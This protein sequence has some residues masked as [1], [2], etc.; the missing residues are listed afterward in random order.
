[1]ETCGGSGPALGM[2]D[3][4]KAC[5]SAQRQQN[6]EQEESSAHVLAVLR[7]VEEDE[8]DPA[9]CQDGFYVSK[10]WLACAPQPPAWASTKPLQYVFIDRTRE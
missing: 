7:Q 5:M 6:R 9:C 3:V 4:C 8:R 1:M 10:T 2:A